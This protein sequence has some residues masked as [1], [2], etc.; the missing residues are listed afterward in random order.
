VPGYEAPINFA[1]SEKNRSPLVRVP[2]KRGMSTRCEVRMPDP[3]CNPYL[4]FAVMLAAGLDGVE[5][6]IDPG[7]PVNKNIF[8]MSQREKR[9]LRIGQLPPNL[10]AALDELEK[11]AVVKDALGDHILEHYLRAKRQEWEEYISHVHPWE[12]DR[13]LGEY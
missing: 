5:R 6:G 8:T 1:W 2:A 11:D 12:Q 4:A 3:S 13:Y 9:R 7:E 10:W